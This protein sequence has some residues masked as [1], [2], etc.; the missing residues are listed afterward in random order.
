MRQKLKFIAGFSLIETV[1][2]LLFV[3]ISVALIAHFID[4]EPSQLEQEQSRVRIDL[5]LIESALAAYTFDHGVTAPTSAEGLTVLIKQGYL[6]KTLLD[7]WGKPYQYKNPGQYGVTDYWSQ[8]PD[9]VDSPDDIV[10][11]DPYGSYVR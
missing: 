11:W 4:R 6:S 3:S 7:P 10:S 9:G 5:R 2:V 8:G 1:I